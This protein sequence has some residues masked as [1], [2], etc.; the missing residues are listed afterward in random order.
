MHKYSKTVDILIRCDKP[1]KLVFGL[2][3]LIIWSGARKLRFFLAFI[4]PE[5]EKKDIFWLKNTKWLEGG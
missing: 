4:C 5:G 2:P 3:G 1:Q